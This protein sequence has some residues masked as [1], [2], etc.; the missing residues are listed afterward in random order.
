M[1]ND[2]KTELKQKKAFTCREEE[3]FLNI[4][5]TA[6]QLQRRMTEI[7]ADMDL[8]RTQYNVLRILR[9]AGEHGLA[10]GEIGERM[11]TRDPDITRLL[12]RMEKR[13]LISRAREKEDRRV[14]TAKIEPAGLELLKKLDG[15]ITQMHRSQLGHIDPK[16]QE[17]FIRLLESAREKITEE[18]K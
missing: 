8:S 12:D 1:P 10:C 14:V 11:I 9:G 4:V 5:R 15:P 18:T 6:D 7:F 17:V 13:K 16:Q 2:I 3:V